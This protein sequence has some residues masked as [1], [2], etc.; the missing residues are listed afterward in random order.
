[1]ASGDKDWIELRELIKYRLDLLDTSVSALN[2][3]S[4]ETNDRITV[5]SN[6][7]EGL[8]G[9]SRAWGAMAGAVGGI[10]AAIVIALL[11]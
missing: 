9:Q 5:V 6:A 8:K 11:T 7:I 10:L 1:M 3:T 2:A 4:K